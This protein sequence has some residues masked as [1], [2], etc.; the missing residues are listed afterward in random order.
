MKTSIITLSILF[1]SIW[2]GEAKAEPAINTQASRVLVEHCLE[3]HSG[4]KPK[5]GLDLSTRKT[6]LKGGES[7]PG[8]VEKRFDK[9][10]LWEVLQE[11]RMPPKNKLRMEDQKTLEDWLR[12]G[13]VYSPEKLDLFSLTTPKRA[14]LDW[15]SLQPLQYIP[16]P[17]IQGLDLPYQ[18]LDLFIL[19]KLEEAKLK[20]SPIADKRTLIRRLYLDLVGLSPT[21]EQVEQFQNDPGPDAYEKLV[22]QLLASPNHGEK[23]ARHWLDVVRYGESDGFERNMGRPNAWHYRDWVIQSL[24]QDLPYDQFARMQIAGDALA[25]GSPEGVSALGF[26]VA[27]VHNTVLGSTEE[28]REQARQDELEDLIGSLGQTF[29]GLTLNCARCHEHKFDPITQMDYYRMVAN[30]SGILHGERSIPAP[31]AQ[32]QYQA[33]QNQKAQLQAQLA[34]LEEPVRKKLGIKGLPFSSGPIAEWDFRK[35]LDDTQGKLKLT[36]SGGARLTPQGLELDGKTGAARSSPITQVITEKTLEVLVQL[37]NLEQRGGGA[38]TLET[39]NGSQFDSIVFGEKEPG[40]WLPGSNNFQRTRDLLGPA[41]S[42]AQQRPV[43]MAITY[44]IDGTIT[45]YRD[46][47]MY[48][49]SYTASSLATFPPGESIIAL[50]IRHEPASGNHTLAGNILKARIFDRVLNASEIKSCFEQS[51]TSLSEA[52]IKKFL[53]PEQ[54]EKRSSL[55]TRL[56]LTTLSLKQIEPSLNIK[57]YSPLFQPPK[58]TRFLHRG[59]VSDPGEEVLP[60][61]ISFPPTLPSHGANQAKPHDSERRLNLSHWITSPNNPLFARVLVNRIWHYHFGTGLVDSPSDFGF[62]GG[63]PSHRELLDHLAGDFIRNNYSIKSIH[64]SIVLS[65]TYRQASTP[66]ESALKLDRD[67][68]LLWRFSPRRLDAEVIRDNALHVCGELNQSM[69]GPSASDYKQDFN[70]GT[71][72]F[73]PLE[74]HQFDSNRR[75]VYRFMPRGANP[76]LL[77]VLDC[78]DNASAAPRRNLTTTPIQSL[79]LWNGSFTQYLAES[80]SRQPSE[81]P[82][83]DVL[84]LKILQRKPT[85]RELAIGNQLI[86]SHGTIPVIR[87]LLNSNEFLTLE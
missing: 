67:N 1:Y 64:K 79:A 22:D 57:A 54:F 8:I 17:K 63:K 24:N 82:S 70:N 30:L 71:T 44:A 27:G 87:A 29:L 35:S 10:V 32:R 5:G 61:Q 7:G 75:S 76:G 80:Q 45:A 56:S 25:P 85:P 16:L 47:R 38:I 3:C 18:P 19:K 69:G 23:W 78:P 72:Y 50:G 6:T 81:T 53:P 62:N 73:T 86:Q 68:R 9:G 40:Q 46:G 14:G 33:L 11:G 28:S 55:Q 4:P 49:K 66:L 37:K 12:S 52:D 77:D 34:F 2:T 41:E 20:P 65:R 21:P 83:V 51:D 36:L 31:G 60:G 42:E 15:W 43:H 13:A 59:Q 58:G 39:K 48:G 74:T 26:L 84:F